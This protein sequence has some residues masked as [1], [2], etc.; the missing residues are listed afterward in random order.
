MAQDMPAMEAWFAVPCPN[1]FISVKRSESFL[2]YS[3]ETLEKNLWDQ[4]TPVRDYLKSLGNMS[5]IN[6]YLY[7]TH[8]LNSYL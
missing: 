7:F 8:Y 1:K 6:N 4:F 3:H 2:R 5:P